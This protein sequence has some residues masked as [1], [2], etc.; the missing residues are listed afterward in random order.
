MTEGVPAHLQL[1]DRRTNALVVRH[2]WLP[3][4]GLLAAGID[5]WTTAADGGVQVHVLDP[6]RELRLDA[7]ALRQGPE[8]V[9]LADGAE[10]A[11]GDGRVRFRDA[12]LDGF[13]S[14]GDAF[15]VAPGATCRLRISAFGLIEGP[16]DLDA[17]IPLPV[18][19]DR[20]A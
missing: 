18:I 2:S 11:C 7:M 20:R 14:T 8:S 10:L 5:W 15:V 6:E 19:A 3:G 9:H 17:A 12:D 13:L 4:F 1:L 16:V